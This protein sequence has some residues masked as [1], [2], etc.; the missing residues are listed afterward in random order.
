MIRRLYVDNYK[1]LVNFEYKPAPLHLLFGENGN[2][3]TTTF[4]VLERLRDY[5]A[6]ASTAHTFPTETLTAWQMRTEQAFC[7]EIEGNGGT[8][9]YS[10]AIQHNRS[11]N[12][13]RATKEELLFDGQPLY[14]FYGQNAHLFRDDHS[15]GAV[16]PHDWSRS[17][18]ATIPEGPVY[19][20]LSWFRRRM[21]RIYVFSIVPT[22]MTSHSDKESSTPARNLANFASWYRHLSQESQKHIAPLFKSLRAV[23]SGF[24]EIKLAQIGETTRVLRVDFEVWSE[25]GEYGYDPITLTL[26]EL[27]EGHR[28]LIALFTI[29]HFVVRPGATICIDE[30]DNFVALRELQPW[31]LE[32]SDRVDDASCQ[33]LIISHHPEFINQ[34]AVKNGVRFTRAGIGPVRIEPFKWSSEDGIP[35][36]EFVARGWET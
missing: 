20:K 29:L 25:D 24:G 34:L 33:C 17:A 28:C 26:D 22:E 32:L 6:G 10:L 9:R 4:E 12:K 21:E 16:F 5:V 30:P 31:L 14:R 3:K 23:I 18:L 35:P 8:Y 36:S 2:G 15:K 19:Q 11:E 27:S 1:C 7:L 13:C